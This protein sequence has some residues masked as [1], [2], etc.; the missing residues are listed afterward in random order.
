MSRTG[1]RDTNCVP[2]DKV[3]AFAKLVD[4]L[5]KKHGGIGK[6]LRTIGVNPGQ[7]HAITTGQQNLPVTLAKK[8]LAT[9]KA[10]K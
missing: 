5:A 10:C 6:A 1:T 7:W 4:A 8:I 3:P 2:R 9:Y